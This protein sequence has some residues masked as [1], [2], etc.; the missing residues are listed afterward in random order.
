MTELPDPPSYLIEYD[1]LADTLS[2]FYSPTI[3]SNNFSGKDGAGE[4]NEWYVNIDN[5]LINGV[6]FFDLKRGFETVDHQILL[7]KFQLY[8]V[9]SLTLRW[10]RFYLINRQRL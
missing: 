7:Q 1:L 5:G 3:Y 10:F 8:E 6:L 2:G 9:D 4:W